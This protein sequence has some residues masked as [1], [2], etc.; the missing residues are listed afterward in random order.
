MSTSAIY[1][2]GE[3]RV[4]DDSDKPKSLG[5]GK[6]GEGVKAHVRRS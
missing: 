2:N 6:A 4:V 1:E 3:G 5:G